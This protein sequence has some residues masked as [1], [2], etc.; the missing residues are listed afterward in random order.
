MKAVPPSRATRTGRNGDAELTTPI[1]IESERMIRALWMVS[2]A[3]GRPG[4]R[5]DSGTGRGGAGRP[6]GWDAGASSVGA[7]ARVTPAVGADAGRPLRSR[8]SGVRSAVIL[9]DLAVT[10]EYWEETQADGTRETGCRV[11]LRLVRTVPAPDPAARPAARRR[12]MAHR[13]PD[14]ARRPVHRGRRQGSVRRRALPSDVR[15][16][17]AL[18]AGQ[19]S[20]DPAP[21]RSAG[22]RLAWPTSRRCCTEAGHAER[23]ADLDP[24]DVRQAMPAIVATIAAT[25]AYRPSD[26][27]AGR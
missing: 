14:L 17:D 4:R 12:R 9:G 8:R 22:S 21:I 3:D 10:T 11:Q 19:R 15:R 20:D 16:L 6:G 24:D 13:A 23:I 1:A 25:L 27:P 5:R 18:R 2:D 26:A 7:A